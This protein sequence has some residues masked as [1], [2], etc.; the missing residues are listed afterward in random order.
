MLL[1]LACSET[2]QGVRLPANH[3]ALTQTGSSTDSFRY[4]SIGGALQNEDDINNM[5]QWTTDTLAQEEKEK[6]DKTMK[7]KVMEENPKE[8]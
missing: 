3:M 5:L 6:T 4:A 7:S 1:L 8:A 2:T